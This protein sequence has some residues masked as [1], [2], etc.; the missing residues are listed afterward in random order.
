MRYDDAATRRAL[1]AEYVLDTLRGPARRRFERLMAQRPDAARRSSAGRS[2]SPVSRRARPRSSRQPDVWS[3]YPRCASRRAIAIAPAARCVGGKR[4]RWRASLAAI[5]LAIALISIEQPVVIGPQVAI[6]KDEQA[7]TGWVVSFA[8]G[9]AGRPELRA[10]VEGAGPI[11]DRVF[12]LWALPGA[13]AAPVSLGLLP[14][15]GEAVLSCVGASPTDTGAGR[16]AR[17]ERRA[18]RGVAHGT[19]DRPVLYQGKLVAI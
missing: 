9:Q 3:A 1:A 6:L 19:A 2:S 10:L 12:E 17:R 5:V 4:S 18:A 7:R 14:V 8:P 11:P 13:G 16:C 15:Q